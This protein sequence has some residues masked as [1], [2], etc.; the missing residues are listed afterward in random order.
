MARSVWKRLLREALPPPAAKIL[1]AIE[2]FK[3]G[4][5]WQRENGRY[6]PYLANFLKGER[7]NDPIPQAEIEEKQRAEQIAKIRKE[8]ADKESERRQAF[9]AKKT[10]LK[11][12]FDDF[13]ARF[14]EE[15][16]FPRVFGQWLAAF[17]KGCAPLAHDVPDGNTLGISGFI[18]QFAQHQEYSHRKALPPENEAVR[19][20]QPKFLDKPH[21]NISQPAASQPMA[22]LMSEVMDKL[23]HEAGVQ[24]YP[25]KATPQGIAA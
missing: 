17:E 12:L 8:A 7:W 14:N 18:R 9:E 19:G 23:K 2:R 20:R 10:K 1:E 13:S 22:N 24:T 11:P 21:V 3:A 15:F 6:I 4:K 16:H 5:D 25:G